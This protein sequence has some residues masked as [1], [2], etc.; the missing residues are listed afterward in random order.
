[1]VHLDLNWHSRSTRL[2]LR[3]RSVYCVVAPQAGKV[4]L[5]I[6]VVVRV[7]SSAACQSA[8]GRLVI[9]LIVRCQRLRLL[10]CRSL[11]IV[12]GFILTARDSF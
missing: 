12:G 5:I 1:M 6:H 7:G 8:G 4:F 10:I 2:Y 3:P 9:V 11:I